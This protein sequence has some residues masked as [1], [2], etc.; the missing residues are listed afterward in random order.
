M[1][2]APKQM[3]LQWQLSEIPGAGSQHGLG[4]TGAYKLMDV[5]AAPSSPGPASRCLPWELLPSFQLP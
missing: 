3:E 4:T 2:M 1:A 5:K